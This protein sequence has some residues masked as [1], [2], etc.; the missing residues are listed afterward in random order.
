MNQTIE[1]NIADILNRLENKIDSLNDKI[2]NV[3]HQLENKIDNVSHQMKTEVK[4]LNDKID[5]LSKD[6]NE[7]NVGVA[8]LNESKENFSKRLDNVEFTNRGIFVVFA[9]ILIG[10]VVSA[11]KIISFPNL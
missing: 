11:V 6:V 8:K 9:S 10:L 1:V 7:V 3:S 5:N 4:T 2:D